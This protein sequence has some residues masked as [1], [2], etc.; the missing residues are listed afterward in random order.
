MNQTQSGYYLEC[1]L[2]IFGRSY[3][4]AILFRDLLTFSGKRPCYI[5]M[6]FRPAFSK[7]G[8]NMTSKLNKFIMYLTNLSEI[9]P[10][11]EIDP[12]IFFKRDLFTKSNL[13]KFVWISLSVFSSWS[14]V[15][16]WESEAKP[17]A[18]PIFQK[19]LQN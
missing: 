14:S 19:G 6:K 9:Y 8:L 4:S 10:S 17:S 5:F 15:V 16:S 2:F 18:N 11:I 7:K 12:S 13:V 1:V 3:S